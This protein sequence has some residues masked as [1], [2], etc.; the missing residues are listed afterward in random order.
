[1]TNPAPQH[2]RPQ[3]SRS[4]LA[5]RTA[6]ALLA[7]SL[8]PLALAGCLSAGLGSGEPADLPLVA[9][10][11]LEERALL[12]L[13]VDRQRYEPVVV[14]QAMRGDEA[15]R[16]AAAVALGR[17]GDPGGASYLEELLAD[18]QP[19]VRRAAAF[20]LGELGFP[21]LGAGGEAG[22]ERQA[23]AR[24]LT[25][26]AADA[27]SE[28]GRLAVEALGKLAVAIAAVTPTLGPLP[29]PERWARLLPSLFRFEEAGTVAVAEAALA[30]VA[31]PALHRQ[32]AYALARN[33]R[34]E[35]LPALRRLTADADPRVR[36][37]AARALGLA[38][39]GGDLALLAP[40]L[41]DA[42]AGPIVQA[43]RAGGLLAAAHPAAAA[44]AAEAWR[45]AFD[46][47]LADPRPQVRLAA[48][49]AAAPWVGP[50][51]LAER[52]A[53]IA[54]GSGGG[55]GELDGAA[56]GA[57]ASATRPTTGPTTRP[58]PGERAAALVAL[59]QSVPAGGA[60]ADVV[61]PLAASAATSSDR[62]LRRAAGTA[63]GNLGGAG[64]AAEVVEL[65]GRR[66]AG[67]GEPAPG[68]EA[69]PGS[70]DGP[71]GEPASGGAGSSRAAA[72]LAAL[73]ADPDPAVR[74]AA[75]AAALAAALPG[76][77]DPPT[78]AAASLASSALL[79]ADAGVRAAALGWLAEHPM[80]PYAG[81]TAATGAALG[82]GEEDAAIAG[83]GALAARAGAVAAE[84]GGVVAVLEQLAADRRWLVR[85]R[86]AAALAGLDRPAPPVVGPEP[87]ALGVYRSIVQRTA[88]P[89]TVE[90]VTDAGAFRLRLECPTA[91]LTCHNF[92][93]LAEQGYYDGVAFHRVVPDF[94]VQDGD[95]RGDGTGGPDWA[96][97]DE[98]N[99]IRYERGVL[100]MALS[101]PHTGGSQWFVTLAPQPHLDG[102][103]TAFGR[104]TSGE[105]VLDRILPGTK[106]ER[107]RE[108]P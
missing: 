59:A 56:D 35:A 4:G 1:M 61:L 3:R 30:A 77:D 16:E 5:A 28:V 76:G 71:I 80:L 67:A 23:A 81:L 105:E 43:L 75:L 100:G 46:R 62:L 15:L 83:V 73:L 106:I 45:P 78:P 41:D 54:A 42:D 98:I 47:L 69:A 31:D 63:L 96:I 102:G 89:R 87:R 108:V 7:A 94:V 34:P 104:L 13:M 55:S 85:R 29:E 68:G 70:P 57:A 60:G 99:R 49:E 95:P 2:P 18:P 66:A 86:A 37:W 33:P 84:R 90:V 17:V 25:L 38:G 6:A 40:L 32:A 19:A 50:A 14:A 88:R 39:D 53:A 91:P 103:Y 97:R 93:L 26:A 44:A 52:L 10:P 21:P 64:L 65:L 101:G 9:V 107:V 24:A 22:P 58:P 8:V 79:D 48:I 74:S 20:A 51:G 82:A 72:L 92:L 12:L 11:H 36:A 27:D